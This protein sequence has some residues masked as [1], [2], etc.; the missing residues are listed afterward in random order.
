MFLYFPENYTWS[1]AVH[2]ALMAGGQLGEFDRQLETLRDVEP[3]PEAWNGAWKKLADQL[4]ADAEEDLVWPFSSTTGQS[5][6]VRDYRHPP[7]VL[8]KPTRAMQPP[9]ATPGQETTARTLGRCWS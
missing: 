4:E 1:A 7:P 9:A 8:R 5:V 6:S 2:L 3:T